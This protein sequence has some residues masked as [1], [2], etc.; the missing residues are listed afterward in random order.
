VTWWTLFFRFLSSSD[1]RTFKR[2]KPPTITRTAKAAE[3]IQ[4][5]FMGDFLRFTGVI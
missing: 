1:K 3:P 5:H 2:K 4:I